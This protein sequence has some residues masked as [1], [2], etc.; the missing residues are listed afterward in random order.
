MNAATLADAAAEMG[1]AKP[2]KGPESYQVEDRG[3]FHGRDAESEQLIARI[4][5]SRFTL[6]H[7]QSGAGKTSLLNACVIPG[8]ESRGWFPVRVLLQNDPVAATRAATL[9]YVL[10]PPDAE[11]VAIRRACR[12]LA[13]DETRSTIADLLQQFDELPTRDARK[14][15]IVSPVESVVLAAAY[16]RTGAGRITPYACR[17]IRASLDLATASEQWSLVR[18]LAARGGD[19]PEPLSEAMPLSELVAA[20]EAPAFVA[21]YRSL[22]AFLDPPGR[23][24]LTEFFANLVEVYGKRFSRFGLVLL[25]DQFEEI[26][27]RFVDAGTV[28]T[29]TDAGLPDWRLR[30]AFF[31]ELQ[32]LY[33][34]EAPLYGEQAAPGPLPIRFVLSMR[35]EYIGKL[36]G[37]RSFVASLD[38]SS[39][40]L[41]LL[42]VD[43][44]AKA[45]RKP[46]Q[47]FG[48]GYEAE[49]YGHIIGDLTKE[50]RYV[51]PTHMQVVCEHLWNAKGR[52]LA[53]QTTA[54]DG[55]S[56]PLVPLAVY[57]EG[58]GVRGMMSAFLWS[59]LNGLAEPER[60]ETVEILE[61]LITPGG[62]RNIV[63]RDYLVNRALRNAARRAGL[64][65]QLVNRTIVRAETRL[66]G[67]FIEITHEFLIAPIKDAIQKVL[68]ANPE[69]KRLALALDALER[70]R[71]MGASGG[72]EPSLMDWEFAALERNASEVDW[73][74][75][76]VETM[77]RNAI[78]H[79]ASTAV[80]RQW[81]DRLRSASGQPAGVD[82]ALTI[83]REF[84]GG[85]E[86]TMRKKGLR[87][88][89]AL[90]STGA[91]DMLVEAALDTSD[92]ETAQSAEAVIAALD[93]A[94]CSNV[95][96]ALER[97]LPELPGR[98]YA[99]LGRLRLLGAPVKVARTSWATRLG[100]ATRLWNEMRR[101]RGW[102]YWARGIAP[103]FF[104][105]VLGAGLSG[106]ILDSLEL[107]VPKEQFFASGIAFTWRRLAAP[108]I[109]PTQLH[110]D[111][112]AGTTA[113]A[114][115][116]AILW[117]ALMLAVV[118]IT[119]RSHDALVLLLVAPLAVATIRV[120]VSGVGGSVRIPGLGFLCTTVVA[121]IAGIM[122][123]WLAT[124]A[125]AALF[126]FDLDRL[127]VGTW[128]WAPAFALAWMFTALDRLPADYAAVLRRTAAPG[129][130]DQRSPSVLWPGPNIRARHAYWLAGFVCLAFLLMIV[131]ATPGDQFAPPPISAREPLKLEVGAAART[132]H[133]EQAPIQYKVELAAR[134]LLAIESTHAQ[135]N[136]RTGYRIEF[137]RPAEPRTIEL[138]RSAE[139]RTAAAAATQP[140]SGSVRLELLDTQEKKTGSGTLGA[141]EYRLSITP[142]L[143]EPTALAR[144]A[145]RTLTKLRIQ[146]EG[147]ANLN[148]SIV[149]APETLAFER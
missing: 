81:A 114:L 21:A 118:A 120:T 33:A 29:R 49:C 45:I 142:L 24:T 147:T 84:I 137:L 112:V 59:F 5:S 144:M 25:F 110:Y 15:E 58:D 123:A 93:A 111:R 74:A 70:V 53:E 64:L 67:Q 125:V 56:L 62:T 122:V 77:F 13:L 135:E 50:D 92:P 39:Y 8:L 136:D 7:A 55:A 1:L 119:D 40:H 140:D 47:E 148:V 42:N 145:R 43:E 131:L 146:P 61:Q 23:S 132:L 54:V 48:Y 76:A 85:A 68:F 34:H 138:L 26:F 79:G 80:I 22:V 51:E 100:R 60:I 57:L 16:P 133:V 44:A 63:E 73:P 83:A 126:G 66:G 17:V 97:R 4:L 88:L 107:N 106:V 124:F 90:P 117:V 65:A 103:A 101:G 82:V 72:T 3:L 102:R 75:W 130:V 38:Q 105:L 86:A 94:A 31:E 6:L 121:A 69:H 128:Y 46:A 19:A 78:C 89:G 99:L 28:A 116:A 30:W 2:Y 18:A 108:W 10:P 95:N 141:G 91:A 127:D 143:E 134:G 12:L 71:A 11:V 109:T 149:L 129:A 36:D 113:D 115:I 41:Q 139:Q 98:T 20:L 87:A 96:L 32:A 27:T 37:V 9:Q 104:G 52:E 35:G 14:R